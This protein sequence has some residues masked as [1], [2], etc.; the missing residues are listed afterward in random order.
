MFGDRSNPEEFQIIIDYIKD[1]NDNPSFFYDTFK[2]YL[3]MRACYGLIYENKD[4][5]I[6]Y[7]H[8]SA[9]NT[10]AIY[11]YSTPKEM[12]GLLRCWEETSNEGTILE[13][14]EL[15]TQYFKRFYINSKQEPNKYTEIVNERKKI[16]WLSIPAFAVENSDNLGIFEN[17]LTLI[18]KYEQIIKNNANT[19][20]YNDDA[21]LAI[22]GYAPKNEYHIDKR[23]EK[24]NLVL[25]EKGNKIRVVNPKRLEEEKMALQ[26]RVLFFPDE[27]NA[28]WIIKEVNDTASQNHKKTCLDMALMITGVPNV[29]D[30]GFTNADNSSALEKKFFPLE[31]VLMRADKQFKKELLRMWEIIIDRINKK[32]NM[33]FDFRDIEIILTRNL[34]QNVNE[35][36]TT[37]LKMR[38]LLSDKTVIDHL[39][40]ELDSDSELALIDTQNEENMQKNLENMKAFGNN[41]DKKVGES[42]DKRRNITKEMEGN[43][44]PTK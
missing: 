24:G 25:D 23:D 36:V 27:G 16:R 10:I 33:K 18:D 1:Y 17:V 37:W 9:L 43:R 31:Q 34:P 2:D 39:P 41:S 15:T 35:I 38:G 7:A 30:E 44:Q 22:F 20:Q 26:S 32:K 40:F 21:K 14:V 4:N 12:I 42:D 29:T 5:E 13:K 6:V 19:F 28:S 8:T 11:D 3:I